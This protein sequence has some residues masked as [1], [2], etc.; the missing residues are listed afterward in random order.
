MKSKAVKYAVFSQQIPPSQGFAEIGVYRN[1]AA[2]A[3]RLNGGQPQHGF[4]PKLAVAYPAY[5]AERVVLSVVRRNS[6][7]RF[8]GK[9]YAYRVPRYLLLSLL[10]ERLSVILFRVVFVG[11]YLLRTFV[12]LTPVYRVFRYYGYRTVS[13]LYKREVVVLSVSF[14]VF[15]RD[16]VPV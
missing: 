6:L 1:P 9:R 13:A 15:E 5:V 4:Y 14:A 12:Y 10:P 3:Y 2:L 16:Y 11:R 7:C 8:Y